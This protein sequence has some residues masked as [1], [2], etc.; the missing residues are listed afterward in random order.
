VA[1]IT[2]DEVEALHAD[3]RPEPRPLAMNPPLVETISAEEHHRRGRELLNERK[4]REA[5]QELSEAIR[6]SSD[7]AL[8][9]NA[10][11]YAYYML[12]D[13]RQANAD[14]VSCPR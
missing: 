11:G 10:R 7:S 8:A 9:Y 13:Y 14:L 2:T 4:Y 5:I 12:H 3:P 1:K 6:Q